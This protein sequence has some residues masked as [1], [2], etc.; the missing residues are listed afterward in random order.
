[1]ST[2]PDTKAGWFHKIVTDP[3]GFVESMGHQLFGGNRQVGISEETLEKLVEM[4][5]KYLEIKRAEARARLIEAKARRTESEAM[6]IE[7][8]AQLIEAAAELLRQTTNAEALERITGGDP[9]VVA[10][11]VESIL[12]SLGNARQREVVVTKIE[13]LPPSDDK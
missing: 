1:M 13:A 2:T 5:D 12:Q 6:H 9:R 7:A 3:I 11:R 10:Q 4:S 8:K